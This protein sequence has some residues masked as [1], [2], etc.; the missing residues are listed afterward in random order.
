MVINKYLARFGIK[1]VY[2][3]I[4]MVKT[5]KSKKG[6]RH[7]QK[8]QSHA[9]FH[10]LH[11]WHNALFEEL[12]WMVL[13]KMHGMNDK[14]TTYINSLHRFKTAVENKLEHTKDS[15]KRADLK[16]LHSNISVLI[17]HAHKDLV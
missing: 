12:G 4:K 1:C 13:A 15:D 6:G 3:Y 8:K 14:T 16:I 17:G 2:K 10:G 5:R 11:R 7:T 9:T